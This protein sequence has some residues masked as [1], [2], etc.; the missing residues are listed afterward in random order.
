MTATTPARPIHHTPTRAGRIEWT[1]AAIFAAIA[2]FQLALAVGA[3][4]GRA[5]WG[6]SNLGV[7]PAGLRMA[8]VG[9]AAVNLTL[10]AVAT[11]RL[12]RH[13]RRGA[14]I[15]LIAF[16]AAGFVSNLATRSPIERA[17]WAPVTAVLLVCSVVMLRRRPGGRTT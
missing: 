4:W 16:S 11:G 7:L 8:S 15:G 10:A 6:G 1:T 13:H 17:I 2:A 9:S 5:A 14:I 12:A 3:P